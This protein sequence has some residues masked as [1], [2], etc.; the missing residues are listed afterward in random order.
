[1]RMRP[2]SAIAW[3]KIGE[4]EILFRHTASQWPT[5]GCCGQYICMTANI[6]E[7]Q[8]YPSPKTVINLGR[9]SAQSPHA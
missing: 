3:R 5:R 7:S 2:S 9:G 4:G 1:M 8:A 6:T